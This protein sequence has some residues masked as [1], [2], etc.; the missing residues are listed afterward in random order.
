MTSNETV[1]QHINKLNVMAEELNA[2]GTEVPPK[3]KVT[4]SF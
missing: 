2:I 1:E 4:W 3:L